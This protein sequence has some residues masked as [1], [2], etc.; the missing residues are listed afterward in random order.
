MSTR[1]LNLLFYTESYPQQPPDKAGQIMNIRN[2][3]EEFCSIC[4]DSYEESPGH[5][6]VSLN[7]QHAFGRKCII[8]WALENNIC[9]VCGLETIPAE[10]RGRES[11]FCRLA[12]RTISGL[13]RE[14]KFVLFL[15]L[16]VTLLV[17]FLAAS[18]YSFNPDSSISKGVGFLLLFAAGSAGCSA[19]FRGRDP[20][21]SSYFLGAVIG[22]GLSALLICIATTPL[23]SSQKAV[24]GQPCSYV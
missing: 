18:H 9:P 8:R 15:G 4:Y 19:Y 24:R 6:A 13:T 10:L 12:N 11:I 7:C 2:S 14:Q 20:L 22:F 3:T 16:S 21:F 5:D 17:G 23:Q 1:R